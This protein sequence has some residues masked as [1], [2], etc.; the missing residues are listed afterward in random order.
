[1]PQSLKA[2]T[3]M[4]KTPIGEMPVDWAT[5][6]LDD[7][8]C[9]NAPI[10]YGI[11]KPGRNV[12]GGVPVIKVKDI[13]NG[14]I[15]EN[16]I[17]LTSPDIDAQYRRSKLLADDL[18][19]T[20]RGSTGDVARIPAS[21]EGANITQDTARLRIDNNVDRDFIFC[22]LQGPFLQRQ[23]KLHTIGQA[24]KGINIAEVRKLTIALPPLPEQK[25]IAEILGTWDRAIEKTEKL[26][27]AKQKLK[28]ALMQQLLTGKT[29]FKEFDGQDWKEYRLG[30]LFDERTE[31]SCNELP[32]LSITSDR[33]VIP[34]DEVARKDTSNVDKSKYLRICPGDIGYNTMRMWQ[35]VSAVSDLEGIVS[36]AYTIC[37]PRQ[38]ID[39]GF[40]AY[41]FKF[42][43]MIHLFWR[44]SQ[45]LVADTLN[46]KFYNFAQIHVRMPGLGEQMVISTVLSRC[47]QEIRGLFENMETLRQQKKGLMQ[48]L[49]T[50]KVRVK[51]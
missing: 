18:L 34:R 11:L 30:D 15:N 32:L 2:S 26:I 36:P 10:C 3:K 22:V 51:I 42:P 1:M 17:L 33:G 37:I 38:F 23:I 48:K 44:F 5:C 20:I 43:P 8:V 49:L 13:K 29:R 41:L 25:K 28:K 27:Q 19:I 39:A 31:Q 9:D 50:G 12:V 35:G 21:L 14:A 46:L 4:K 6:S 40:A 16:G 47:E 45:G 7:C 24:V